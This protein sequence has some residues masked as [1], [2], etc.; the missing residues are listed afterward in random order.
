M[1]FNLACV[2]ACWYHYCNR[3]IWGVLFTGS[4]SYLICLEMKTDGKK[5][6]QLFVILVICSLWKHSNWAIYLDNKIYWLVKYNHSN[7]IIWKLFPWNAT[8]GIAHL[9]IDLWYSQ[10][11][12]KRPS[13][14]QPPVLRDQLWV[15][16]FKHSNNPI[17]I[18]CEVN[19]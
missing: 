5:P 18:F 11:C 4:L 7:G 16:S 15:V 2:P 8:F 14:Q 17:G 19:Q 13:I 12:I 10:I 9:I 3:V 6:I 1:L